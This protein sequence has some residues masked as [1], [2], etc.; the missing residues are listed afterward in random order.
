MHVDEVYIG[1]CANGTLTDLRQAASVLSGRRAAKGTRLITVPATRGIYVEALRDGLIDVFI[2][3]GAVISP[4]TCDACAG[5]HMGLLGDGETAVATII[6]TSSEEWVPQ[7]QA[8]T[9]LM[10]MWRRQQ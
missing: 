10:H 6:G 5:L 1:N 2:N 7:R 8:C 4:P 3:A 9:W